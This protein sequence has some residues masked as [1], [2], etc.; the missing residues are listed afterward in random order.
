MVFSEK[1]SVRSLECPPK[2]VDFR[3]ALALAAGYTEGE[4][5]P[6]IEALWDNFL[7]DSNEMA[8]E[9]AQDTRGKG[10]Q[11]LVA[12]DLVHQEKVK[13][14]IIPRIDE[15]MLARMKPLARLFLEKLRVMDKE[16][17]IWEKQSPGK[18][19]E[20]M[21]KEYIKKCDG[22][23][24]ETHGQIEKL[25]GQVRNVL[26]V[27][28]GGDQIIN[29]LEE[30]DLFNRNFLPILMAQIGIKEEITREQNEVFSE[31]MVELQDK[32]FAIVTRLHDGLPL[33]KNDYEFIIQHLTIAFENEGALEGKGLAKKSPDKAKDLEKTLR[34]L[35]ATNL[36]GL[37]YAMNPKQCLELG[38]TILNDA[39]LSLEQKV[40]GVKFLTV[41]N[42]LDIGQAQFLL[43]EVLGKRALFKEE[44]LNKIREAQIAVME[45][46][47]SA[48]KYLAEEY[49]A[50]FMF[51]HA[52][53]PNFLIY[54]I[55][56]HV[57][58]IGAVL[59]FLLNITKP[60]QWIHLAMNPMVVA[61]AATSGLAYNYV[62]EGGLARFADRS[63]HDS[64]QSIEEI[65]K[66]NWHQLAKICGNNPQIM[67]KLR[68]DNDKLLNIIDQVSQESL[69]A[70]QI[71]ELSQYEF[72]F[73]NLGLYLAS[74]DPGVKENMENLDN[75][76]LSDLSFDELE[77]NYELS[78][79]SRLDGKSL[80]EA[81][82]I[83]TDIYQFL[84]A[85]MGCT[86]VEQMAEIL[87][88]VNQDRGLS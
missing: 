73:R 15:A 2:A 36:F 39:K 6:G 32:T 78:A 24:A 67:G 45:M 65:E 55:V 9:L 37:V 69:F 50:N 30:V 79:D 25:D 14:G 29:T 66:R 85:N 72:N 26:E 43:E 44:E 22:I 4:L 59:P 12:A 31:N 21:E 5:S 68:A 16:K 80:I 20:E 40:Q 1:S 75:D 3:S 10:S 70:G 28:G 61:C 35:E 82:K 81:E 86:S 83:I 77:I 46:K 62:T 63:V 60:D 47:K 52:T 49:H 88:K 58:M 51:S 54:E 23:V 64:D 41:M 27:A 74:K 76:R 18:E 8:R 42:F 71:S 33:T 13:Y 48:G 53:A 57:A 11:D 17:E 7:E 19:K 34:G 56:G 87:D 38:R 84:V